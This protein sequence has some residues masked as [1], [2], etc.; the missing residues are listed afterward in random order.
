[1]V[2]GAAMDRFLKWWPVM[3]AFAAIAVTGVRV[4]ANAEANDLR[5]DSIQQRLTTQEVL[6]SDFRERLARVEATGQETLRG[7]TRIERRLDSLAR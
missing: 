5:I 6:S 7:V 1:M 3:V 4:Q 2:T